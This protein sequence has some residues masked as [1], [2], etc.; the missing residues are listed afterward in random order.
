M[1]LDVSA[2]TAYTDEISSGLAKQIVLQANTIKG[3]L[4]TKKYGVLE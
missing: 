1:A 2:L 3:D 4:V